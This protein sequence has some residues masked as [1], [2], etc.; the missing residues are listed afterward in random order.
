MSEYIR[1]NETIRTKF[2]ELKEIY[3]LGYKPCPFCG[4]QETRLLPQSMKLHESISKKP[5]PWWMVKCDICGAQKN[6]MSKYKLS[7][8]DAWNMRPTK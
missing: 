2:P 1:T 6:S 7:A 8:R 4:G 3:P 5:L